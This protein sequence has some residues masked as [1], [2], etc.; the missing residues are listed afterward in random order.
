ME[1]GL[2]EGL[3]KIPK[4]LNLSQDELNQITEKQNQLRDELE[5]IAKSITELFNNNLDYDNIS[6]TKRIFN[7]L[8]DILPKKYRKEIKKS[9]MKQNIRKIFQKK[10]KKK[11]MNIL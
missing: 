9:L 2:E 10:K 6:D 11:V 5:R 7:S 8:R 3:E 4:I 1:E